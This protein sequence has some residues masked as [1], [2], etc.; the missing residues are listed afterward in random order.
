MTGNT[1]QDLMLQ[2]MVAM[3]SADGALD[4]RE[5]ATIRQIFEKVTGEPVTVEAINRAAGMRQDAARPLTDDLVAARAQLDM[6]TREEIIRAGYLVLLADERISGEER[7]RLK[8]IA[9]ALD[10]SEVHFGAILEEL[11]VSLPTQRAP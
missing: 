6:G 10:V 3:A 5:V 4:E 7:K 11:A 1:S 8:D 2:A 9:A